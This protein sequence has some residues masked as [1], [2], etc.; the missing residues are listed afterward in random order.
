MVQNFLKLSFITRLNDGVFPV[1]FPGKV[2]G[3]R[4]LPS[5]LGVEVRRANW[6][7]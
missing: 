6:H 3:K 7:Q 4:K 1:L 5:Y 2:P